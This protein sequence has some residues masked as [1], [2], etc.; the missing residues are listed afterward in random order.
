MLIQN[1]PNAD[2][3]C[4]SGL[5]FKLLKEGVLVTLLLPLDSPSKG[6]IPAPLPNPLKPPPPFPE[7]NT[8][9]L[10]PL[11]APPLSDW[12]KKKN[13]ED[14]LLHTSSPWKSYA[15]LIFILLLPWFSV[16]FGCIIP[17]Q[18]CKQS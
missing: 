6:F 10:K 7:G 12:G 3:V 17:S 13:T 18:P 8:K 15:H 5:V 14:R 4:V 9:P 1:L 16:S 2:C 11:K